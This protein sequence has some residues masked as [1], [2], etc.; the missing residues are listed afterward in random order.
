MQFWQTLHRMISAVIKANPRYEPIQIMKVD[1]CC[2]KL[3]LV[4]PP[5]DATGRPLVAMPLTLPI[6]WVES[7]PWFSTVTKTGTDL[8]NQQLCRNI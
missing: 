3:A 5:P 2:P 8:A 1:V 4:L 6:D 7:P